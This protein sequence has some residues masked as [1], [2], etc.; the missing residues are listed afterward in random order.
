MELINGAGARVITGVTDEFGLYR[1][2]GV[3]VGVYTL[4]VS[5]Q[6]SLNPNDSLPKLEIQIRNQFV[7]DRNL[8]LPISAAAKKKQ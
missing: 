2:D 6:D 5:P 3:P 4:R 7:Y 8:Q 1:L